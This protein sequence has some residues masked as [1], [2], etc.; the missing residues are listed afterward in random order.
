MKTVYNYILLILLI[1]ACTE[2]I[3][4]KV[5]TGEARLTVDARIT[6]DNQK[7]FVRLTESSE[8]FYNQEAKPITDAIVS[9]NDGS[10][11]IKFMES[12]PG[13]YQSETEFRGL[14]GKQYELSISNVDIN[15]D[16]TDENYSAQAQMPHPYSVDSIKMHYDPK[17]G[18]GDDE[19]AYWLVSLYM[20][21]NPE[22][23]N[24]YGFGCRINDK[25]VTDTITEL[26][27][28]EDIY[29]NGETTKGVDVAE[30]FQE[31]KD[32]IVKNND[33]ITLETYSINQDYYDFLD[34][35]NEMEEGQNPVF[36]GPP[37]NIST[38]VSNGAVGFF[39]VYSITRTSTIVKTE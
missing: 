31:Q 12:S 17:Y 23:D 4:I 18:Y 3:D 33:Q 15:N 24:F 11:T 20:K 21:D 2:K 22:E 7:H 32:E 27:I 28:A 13:F 39:A 36:S 1:S 30:L 19:G 38:N 9:V 37:A 6:S 8:V 16:G 34:Q 35:L 5:D 14:P 26:T 10:R 25:L 29:F